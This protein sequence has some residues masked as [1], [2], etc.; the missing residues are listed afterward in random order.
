MN[1]PP[2]SASPPEWR[3]PVGVSSG[4]WDYVNE[5]TIADHYD[6]FVADTPLCRLDQQIVAAEFP[7][8]KSGQNASII[9]LGC[10]SGRTAL[11][12]AARGYTVIGV[13]LSHRMLE[14]LVT[15]AQQQSLIDRIHPV[16]ANLVQID[17]FADQSIDHAVCMFSTLGMIQGGSNRREMLRSL[18][19]IVRPGGKFVLH[20]HNRW[21][22]LYEPGGIRAMVAS[23]ARLWFNSDHEFG[24]SVYAYRGLDKMFMHRFSRKELAADLRATGWQVRELLRV[25]TDGSAIVNR[26][27]G[28]VGGFIVIAQ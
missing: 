3:R 10:G 11:P 12:L 15:K 26:R 18:R 13:D 24:D 7:T 16:R 20:V 17:G 8:R 22:A 1:Q 25:A 9:D 23:R 5:R 6:A 4:T 14:I 19:R 21:A 2:K 27:F 28:K